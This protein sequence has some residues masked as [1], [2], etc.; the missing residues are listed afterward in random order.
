MRSSFEDLYVRNPIVKWPSILTHDWGDKTF[1]KK[2]LLENKK[3]NFQIV[4]SGAHN[5]K[6]GCG[7]YKKYPLISDL[8]R[9]QSKR[10]GPLALAWAVH[11]RAMDPFFFTFLCLIFSSLLLQTMFRNSKRMIRIWKNAPKFYEV[12]KLF[13]NLKNVHE[14][15][16]VPNLKNLHAFDNYSEFQ[17]GPGFQKIFRIQKI[18]M[19][20]FLK[21]TWRRNISQN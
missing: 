21:S 4:T 1:W 5:W 19:I 9:I 7:F 2:N 8:V 14:F 20:G 13:V 12:F 11:M 17:N 18:F 10:V 3:K 15:E 16:T 6:G